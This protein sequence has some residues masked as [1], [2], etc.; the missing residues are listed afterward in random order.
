MKFADV[1]SYTNYTDIKNHSK[2]LR[3][4]KAKAINCYYIL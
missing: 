4:R 3:K 2:M 1:P